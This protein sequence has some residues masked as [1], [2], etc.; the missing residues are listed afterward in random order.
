M[1]EVAADADLFAMGLVRGAGG[2]GL[3]IAEGQ[4]VMDIVDDGLGPP[5]TGRDGAEQRPRQLT[6]GIGLAVAAAEQVD[7]HVIRQL[8]DRMLDGMG[9][10]LVRQSAVA[11]EEIGFE[12]NRACGSNQPVAGVAE[13]VAIGP[14]ADAGR[15]GDGVGRDQIAPPLGPDAEHE[16]H[17]R[18]EGAF[19]GDLVAGADE[20]TGLPGRS[21]PASSGNAPQW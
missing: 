11:D 3:M 19:E 15:G 1:R 5:P 20:H 13:A 7:E 9:R 8:V 21:P 12:A 14:E 2:P 17:R 18:R 6:Q 16:D 10:D 4:P